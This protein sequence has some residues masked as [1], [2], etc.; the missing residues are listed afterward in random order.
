MESTQKTLQE[1]ACLHAPQDHLPTIMWESVFLFVQRPQICMGTRI[2]AN[3]L[4]HALQPRI[5]TQ[6]I[7]PDFVCQTVLFRSQHLQIDWREDA[8]WAVQFPDSLTR[9]MRPDFVRPFA[10]TMGPTNRMR[11]TQLS[12]VWRSVLRTQS[13]TRTT[14]QS[15]V[16]MFVQIT[17]P[18]RL[19]ATTQRESAPQFA[20]HL[21]FTFR[22]TIWEGVCSNAQ[23]DTSLTL[24]A[25]VACWSVQSTEMGQSILLETKVIEL[26]RLSAKSAGSPRIPRGSVCKTVPETSSR[27]PT[28]DDVSK[29][30]TGRFL[31]GQTTAVTDVLKTVRLCRSFLL[32]TRPTDACSTAPKN[33][34][35]ATSQLQMWQRESVCNFAPL[36][37]QESTISQTT[38]PEDVSLIAQLI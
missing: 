1:C 20:T 18:Q 26:A 6:T 35:P 4:R 34:G 24:T 30:V 29:P 19:T 15:A 28:T 27:I 5:F 33:S 9:I 31:N 23:A 3:V 37:P 11:T 10:S 16:C 13:T 8:Y 32:I 25:E 17:Q 36:T 38:T 2:T 12:S 22:I 21:P 7:R 14:R